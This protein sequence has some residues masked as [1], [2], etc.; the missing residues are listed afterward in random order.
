MASSKYK[1]GDTIDG[2][3]TVV[4][5][6]LGEGGM[7]CVLLV[8]DQST[9]QQVALKYC[10][11]PGEAKRFTREVRMMQTVKHPNVMPVLHHNLIHDPPYFTMPLATP[12]TKEVGQPGWDENAALDV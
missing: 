4:S 3:F 11:D 10:K 8:L 7:G 5:N 6:D 12:I 9:R 1:N 2:R